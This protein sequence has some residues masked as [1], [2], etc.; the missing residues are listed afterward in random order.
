ML[1]RAERCGLLIVDVQE[2]LLPHMHEA[3][4]LLGNCAWLIDVAR[5]LEIP[6]AASEQYP[7]GLGPTVGQLREKLRGL[8]IVQKVSFSCAQEPA[9]LE[10]PALSRAQIVVAGIEAHVCVLQTAAELQALGKDVFVVADAVASRAA[11][12]KDLACNRLRDLGV[13][14]VSRE[15]VAFEWLQRAGTPLFREI[16]REFLR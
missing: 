2:K 3:Q 7:Q 8:P 12:S 5:R 4:T 6:I 14:I 10:T 13:Q 16:S 1:M 15:M 9:V 11:S